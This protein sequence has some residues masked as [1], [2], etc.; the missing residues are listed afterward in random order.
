M[1]EKRFRPKEV[2]RFDLLHRRAGFVTV[3]ALMVKF[4]LDYFTRVCRNTAIK[5]T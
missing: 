3:S 4:L 1:S 2:E 5:Q